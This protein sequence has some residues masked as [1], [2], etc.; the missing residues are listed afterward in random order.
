MKNIKT[1]VAVMGSGLAGLSAALTLAERGVDVTLFEKRPFQG[2]ALS[3]TPMCT[4]AVKNDRKFQDRAFEVHCEF[5]NY[6]GNMG[7]ARR[8]INNSW[9]IPEF[10]KG[11]GLDFLGVVETKYEEIGTINGYTGGFPKGMNLGDYYLLKAR[12]K[13]HGAALI[14]L[15]ARLRLEKLGAHLYFNSKL[16]QILTEDGKVTGA[17]VED[18]KTGEKTQVD[19]KAVVVATGGFSDNPEMIQENSP[20]V[21]TDKDCSGNGNV[22]F[23]HFYNGQMDGDGHKAVWAVGGAKAPAAMYGRHLPGPGIIG[24]VPWLPKD[25]NNLVTVN[26][27]PYLMVNAYG[28]RFIN[29]AHGQTSINMSAAM[30]SQP[31]K[32]AYLIFDDAA[33][34]HLAEVGTDYAYMIFPAQKITGLREQIDRVINVYG[35]KNICKADSLEEL[36][37]KAGIEKEGLQKTVARYNSLCDQGYDEDFGKA[38]QY[39]Y[40]VRTGKLYCIRVATCCYGTVGGIRVNKNCEVIKEDLK[41]IRGLYSAGDCMAGELYGYPARTVC[42]LSTVSFTTGFICADEAERYIKEGE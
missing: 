16:S 2:G 14:C 23:N 29:E 7:L 34:D 37:E 17:I 5:T 32:I 42:N 28:E 24:Y 38:P 20:F 1:E 9:R 10:I 8:W 40:P 36:A 18:N 22:F 13:G 25:D 30:M 19:C 41:P 4:M 12:G 39:L 11:L 21:Y 27:Q 31:G 15:R 26:E 6:S 3:N 35:S 33:I